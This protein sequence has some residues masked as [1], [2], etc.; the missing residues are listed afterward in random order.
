[1][2]FGAIGTSIALLNLARQGWDSLAKDYGGYKQAGQNIAAVQ[3][4]FG[5]ICYLIDK[6]SD[7]W[8]FNDPSGEELFAVYWGED[9]RQRIGRQMAAIDMKCEDLAAILMPF[10][11]GADFDQ[12]TRDDRN[13]V[14]TRLENRKQR[15]RQEKRSRLQ[16]SRIY[17][18]IL[19]VFGDRVDDDPR[20]REIGRSSRP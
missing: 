10:H 13:R 20:D 4:R 5:N 17:K 8:N 7:T 19:N 2:I 16:K 9:G 14:Q 6:W 12:I 15:A 1:M 3:R 18:I 11:S